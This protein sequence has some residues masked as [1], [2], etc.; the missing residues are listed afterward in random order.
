[1]TDKTNGNG[2]ETAIVTADLSLDEWGKR[3][4]IVALSRRIRSMLPGGNKMGTEQAMALAQYAIALDANPFRGEIYGFTSRGRFVLVDGYKVLVRWAKRQCP[5][6]ERC[7]PLGED[8]LSEGDIGFRCWI[9]RDDARATLRDLVQAGAAFQ[10]AYEIA[11]TSAVG[12][13]TQA[14]R[15]DRHGKPID[16]PKGWTWDQV[17]RKRALKNA[18]NLSHGAPSPREIARESWTVGGTETQPGDWR[19]CTP[20]MLPV[21]RER[22]ALLHAQARTQEPDARPPE[23]ILAGNGKILHGEQVPLI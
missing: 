15:T 12:I 16:P 19:E 6:S 13:V 17:A 7:V 4:D 1:M 9:L 21:E 10:E 20:E 5:Y 3:E 11:A 23:E 2:R 22:L 18:L 8:E 14:D